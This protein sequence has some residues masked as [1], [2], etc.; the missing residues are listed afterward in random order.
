M[1]AAPYK[2]TL[3]LKG[4]SNGKIVHMPIAFDDVN[5][6]FATFPDGS[7][8]LQLASDQPY[9]IADFIVVT[10]G[11]DTTTVDI[12]KNNLNSSIQMVPK[13]NL[14]TSNNR[15]FQLNPVA[16]EAGSLMKFKQNT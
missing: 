16:F 10:G 6:N 3:I 12:F 14:N 7:T 4:L 2:A 13:A 8:G 15:Q 1:V 5:T 9:M 11:T